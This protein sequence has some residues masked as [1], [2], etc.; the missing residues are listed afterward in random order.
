MS[1]SGPGDALRR[2]TGL[3]RDAF[4]DAYWSQQ[5]LLSHHPDG[6]S[7]LLS[8][9]DIDELV[10]LRGL[11]TPFFRVVKAGEPAAKA[12]RTTAAGHR[13][14][15]DLADPDVIRERYAAGS[16]LVLQSLHRIHPPLV[17]FCRELA[18]ELGHATQ[19]NAYVTPP[20]SQ[21][22]SP[23][24]DTHDVFVL[25]VDGFKRWKVY[26]PVLTLPLSSQ[27]SSALAT[28]VPLVAEGTA[29]LLSRYLM[30]ALA[31]SAWIFFSVSG[32]LTSSLF[33]MMA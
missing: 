13:R 2:C 29:P 33:G 12:T 18:A 23:H 17:R 32:T 20:G 4:A 14:I 19:C 6:F 22:F 7:D 15:S 24:H 10:A 26:E 11:R 27:P 28:H 8:A 1:R 21:G 25:Q 30:T 16:T 9:A 31:R 5:P 3:D